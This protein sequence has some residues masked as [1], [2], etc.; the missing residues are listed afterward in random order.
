MSVQRY[1]R[2]HIMQLIRGYL[3]V[4][5]SNTLVYCMFLSLLGNFDHAGIYSQGA[6]CLYREMCRTN[7]V[8]SLEIDELLILLQVYRHMIDFLF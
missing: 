5:K 1:A 2:T 4:D 3:I 8:Q 7:N 6:T